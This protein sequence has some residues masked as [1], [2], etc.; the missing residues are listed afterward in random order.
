MDK[1]LMEATI[2]N[3]LLEPV[4]DFVLAQDS[5][6]FKHPHQKLSYYAFFRILMY[7]FIS[8]ETSFNVFIKTKLKNGLSPE[9]LGLQKI[10]DTTC[11]EAFERFSVT[12]FQDIFKYFLSKFSFK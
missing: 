6:L 7:F 12:L 3:K 11:N 5:K 8:E 2:F 4:N 1:N 10:A 9:T